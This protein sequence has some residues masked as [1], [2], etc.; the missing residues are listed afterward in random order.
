LEDY[1]YWQ[2]VDKKIVRRINELIKSAMLTPFDGIEIPEALKG[3]LI[4]GNDI[5]VFA[6]KYLSDTE[7]SNIRIL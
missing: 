7:I 1:L 3:D 5:D 6:L 4:E 2:K